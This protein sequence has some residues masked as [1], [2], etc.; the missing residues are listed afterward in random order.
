LKEDTLGQNKIKRYTD[1]L[2][3]KKAELLEVDEKIKSLKK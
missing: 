2:A 3:I 1:E